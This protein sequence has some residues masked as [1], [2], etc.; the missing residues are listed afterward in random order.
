M[1]K[2]YGTVS[3]DQQSRI[4]GLEFVQGL[5]SGALPLNTIARTLG[6]DVTEAERGRV[7]HRAGADRRP[8]Q[9]GG[10]G[11]RWPHGDAA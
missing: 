2:T 5:V 6:Y 1:P 3:T 4:S 7:G 8:P 9:S 10:H 11:P